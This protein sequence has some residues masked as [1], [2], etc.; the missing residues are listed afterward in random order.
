MKHRY[1]KK[2]ANGVRLLWGAPKDSGFS[3][4]EVKNELES[5][6][7]RID[8]DNTADIFLGK[9]QVQKYKK[10]YK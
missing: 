1:G 3:P 8:S 2:K 6:G 9:N 10:R 7:F 4:D 5:N